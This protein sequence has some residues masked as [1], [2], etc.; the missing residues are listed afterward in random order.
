MSRISGNR[1]PLVFDAILATIEQFGTENARLW[2]Y[3]SAV[4]EFRLMST[5]NRNGLRGGSEENAPETL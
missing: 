2:L 4:D 5:R 1:F 3:G